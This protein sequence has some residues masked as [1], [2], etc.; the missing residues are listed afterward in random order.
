MKFYKLNYILVLLFLISLFL[1]GCGN[2]QSNET[3]TSIEQFIETPTKDIY[4]VDKANLIKDEDKQ[5]MLKIGHELYEKTKGQVVVVTVN[6]LENNNLEDV[7][8]QIFNQFGIG[9]KEK[10]NGVLLFIALKDRKIRIETGSGVDHILTDNKCKDELNE[11]KIHF[12]KKDYSGGILTVYKDLVGAVYLVDGEEEMASSLLSTEKIDSFNSNQSN[13]GLF[14][15][16][17][18]FFI[19]AILP[20]KILI[21]LVI[22][23]IL[24]IIIIN[25]PFFLDIFFTCLSEGGSSSDSFSGGSSDGG[26]SSSDW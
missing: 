19:A 17:I 18:A 8:N 23:F 4:V 10:N 15:T 20:V 25:L 2:E 26:G 12:K 16:L 1:S 3:E 24:Y 21:I 11:L 14:A 5:E 6:S 22:L 13:S 7:T 9:N